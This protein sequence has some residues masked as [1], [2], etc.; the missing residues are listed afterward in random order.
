MY[1][2]LSEVSKDD[3]EDASRILADSWKNR[4]AVN[5]EKLNLE[6]YYI[7]DAPDYPENLV[8]F[9][10]DLRY[11]S[12]DSSVKRKILAGAWVSYNEKTIGVEVSIV[13]PACELLLRGVF[14]GVDTM[15]LKRVVAQTQVDEQFHILMCLDACLIARKK[16]C[17]E[18]LV[19]PVPLVVKELERAIG[20]STS[21]REMAIT[22]LAFATVAEVTINAYL[23]LLSNDKDIQPLNR[24]TTALH[25]KDESSHNKIFRELAKNIFDELSEKEKESFASNLVLGLEAF[26]KADLNAWREILK[27]L[28]VPEAD[29]IVCDSTKSNSSKKIIR[30]YSGFR[31]L[32]KELGIVEE[33][34]FEF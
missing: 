10:D 32:L 5:K 30:D 2:Q 16:H 14:K 18:S 25:R 13:N 24:E 12:L 9:K 23:G 34:D 20:N 19:I 27:H 11:K 15:P 29:E 17:I 6:E 7:E 3:F 31:T 26:V 8:P 28:N 22:R 1:T 4:V 33:V 21:E